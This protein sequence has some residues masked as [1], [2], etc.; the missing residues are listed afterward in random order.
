M[1]VTRQS[2]KISRDLQ[3][4]YKLRIL[5]TNGRLPVS[6]DIARQFQLAGYTVYCVDPMSTH[7]CTFSRAVKQSAQI[8]APH[9]NPK[10]YIRAVKELAIRWEI[11]MIIPLHEEVFCLAD[12]E[13]PEILSRLF[14]PPFDMLVHLHDR[15]EFTR[16]MEQLGMLVPRSYLCRSI[17]DVT[18]LPIDQFPEGLVLRPCFG[19]TGNGLH[20]L[21]AGKPT[22]EDL[23]V[24]EDKWCIAQE[25][26][27][28][29]QYRSYSVIRDGLVE[30][31]ACHDVLETHNSSTKVVLRQKFHPG[32]YEYV[33]QFVASVPAFSGQIAFDFIETSV[34]LYAV[35]CTPHAT[36]GLHLWAGTQ[37][38]ARAITGSLPKEDIERPIR[39]PKRPL[40]HESH[41]QVAARMLT[42]EHKNATVGI[43]LKHMKRLA[44]T[45]D[46]VWKL[47][48]PMPVIAEPFL[49]TE[50]YCMSRKAGL[51]LPELFEE[52]LLWEPKGDELEK[53]RGMFAKHDS[54]A[55]SGIELQPVE[56]WATRTLTTTDA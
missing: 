39:P 26:L 34:G 15:Y 37:W 12:S 22:P 28:G 31:T 56:S 30:A 47:K 13:E 10:G 35:K 1:P 20:R 44:F 43:W 45:R 38:L 29:N 36:S 7:L 11:D 52:Q 21:M 4:E 16:Y 32:V 46:V 54:V 23:E 3:Q 5:I 18:Q 2:S 49:L 27:V 8:P 48:D 6:L 42:W 50:Y 9:N 14:A 55:D 25:W 51:R 40:G 19:R 41:S 33:H 24:R 53:I 17:H